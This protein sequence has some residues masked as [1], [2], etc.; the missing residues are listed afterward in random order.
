MVRKDTVYAAHKIRSLCQPP[1][2]VYPLKSIKIR[3]EFE[4]KAT[5]LR[6]TRYRGTPPK[7]Q[8][9]WM[10]RKTPHRRTIARSSRARN[11]KLAKLRIATLHQLTEMFRESMFWA[12]RSGKSGDLVFSVVVRSYSGSRNFGAQGSSNS[13]HGPLT[14]AYVESD[15]ARVMRRTLLLHAKAVR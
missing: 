1:R 8:T 3:A 6:V 5:A 14:A 13:R 4:A 9:S 2:K 11:K 10:S 15:G 7:P 12:T